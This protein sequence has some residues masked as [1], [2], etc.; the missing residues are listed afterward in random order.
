M[1][2]W[3]ANQIIR[4]E[5][6]KSHNSKIGTPTMGG[7][8]VILTIL[9][10]LLICGNFNNLY[11]IILLFATIAFGTIGFIDDYLKISRKT[12]D[13][14]H[15]KFKLISQIIVAALITIALYSINKKIGID[16][17][18]ITIPFFKN[19]KLDFTFLNFYMDFSFFNNILPFNIPEIFVPFG[20]VIYIFLGIFI[21]VAFSNA[22]NVTD[23]LDGLA[24]GLLIAVVI[25]VGVLCYLTGHEKFADYLYLDFMSL[26][27]ELLVYCFAFIGGLCGFLWF[28]SHPAQIFMGD[29]GSIS[30]GGIIGTMALMIKQELLLAIIGGVFV[31]EALSVVIQV[32]YFKIFKKRIFL[33]SPIHHHF[34]LK[35]WA[36]SKII[37]RFWIIGGILAVIAIGS[38]KL[39]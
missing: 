38:L 17:A 37:T 7:F 9:V 11:I 26:S 35:G 2:K 33:M 19:L 27:G 23:G 36:E 28:N 29:T 6:P 32:A 18:Y 3:K 1:T 16:T 34:E 8:L 25:T 14:L 4:E 22:V 15:A 5:G 30:F 12:S 21:I 24:S 10:S 39:R 20:V 13:G 31:A